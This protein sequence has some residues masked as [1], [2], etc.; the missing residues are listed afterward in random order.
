[1]LT[2]QKVQKAFEH[3]MVNQQDEDTQ[4]I[5]M[6]HSLGEK[7]LSFEFEAP[8]PDSAMPVLVDRG[9]GTQV[10]LVTIQIN[11]KKLEEE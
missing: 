10:A 1:M 4:N 5:M 6:R 11:I 3:L 2:A 8:D 7:N 9:D